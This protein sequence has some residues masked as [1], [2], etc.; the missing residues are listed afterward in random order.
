MH[1][2]A[3]L[4]LHDGVI[5]YIMNVELIIEFYGESKKF[6]NRDIS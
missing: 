1:S 6:K 3:H 2:R 5:V 4:D